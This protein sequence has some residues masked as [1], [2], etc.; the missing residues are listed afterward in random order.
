VAHGNVSPSASELRKRKDQAPL[1]AATPREGSGSPS[2]PWAGTPLP[3]ATRS[4][5]PGGPG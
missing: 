4:R 1:A 5:S 3:C 2:T